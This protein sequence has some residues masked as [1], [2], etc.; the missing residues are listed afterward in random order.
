MDQ[1]QTFQT[2]TL[3]RN[4]ENSGYKNAFTSLSLSLSLSLIFKVL[5]DTGQ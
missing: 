5:N 4:S 2:P 1:T 3:F